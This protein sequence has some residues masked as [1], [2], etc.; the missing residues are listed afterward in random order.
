[1]YT[2]S[3]GPQAT[4]G[5]LHKVLKFPNGCANPAIETDYLEYDAFGNVL[6]EIDANGV[7]TRYGWDGPAH[8]M[9]W[10]LAAYNTVEEARTQ[11]GYENGEQAW[12]QNPLGDYEVSCHQSGATDAC[13]GGTWTPRVQWRAKSAS[14]SRLYV[15]E[16]ASP[17]GEAVLPGCDEAAGAGGSGLGLPCA[18]T[19]QAQVRWRR[20]HDGL[21]AA[22]QRGT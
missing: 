17:A 3:T 13:Q 20:Q 8:K 15:A 19:D 9:L 12:V 21:G 6:R 11:Y 18:G 7:E 4:A 5:Q 22:V 14:S 2:K 1:M 16:P 10:R